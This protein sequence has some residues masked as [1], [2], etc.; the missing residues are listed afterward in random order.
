MLNFYSNEYG[1]HLDPEQ[2]TQVARLVHSCDLLVLTMSRL[3]FHAKS[4]ETNAY[5][6]A[7]LNKPF[8]P[9]PKL[10]L[11]LKQQ[12]DQT[13]KQLLEINRQTAKLVEQFHGPPGEN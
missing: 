3:E 1:L 7:I 8:A 4:L 5:K 12:L 9:D 11:E 6:S 13:E 10:T 2:Q